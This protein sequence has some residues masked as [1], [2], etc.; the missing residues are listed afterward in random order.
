MNPPLILV[1]VARE[2]R[3]AA[4]L[5]GMPRV[6][7]VLAAEQVELARHFAGQPQEGLEIPW[8]KHHRPPRLRGTVAWIECQPNAEMEAGDHIL[9]LSRVGSHRTLNLEPLP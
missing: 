8:S 9:F 2:A 1:S 7:N 4:G 6:V 5:R 3:A